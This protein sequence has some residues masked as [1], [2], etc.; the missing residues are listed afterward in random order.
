MPT[1]DSAGTP[2]RLSGARPF[3]LASAATLAVVSLG[4]PWSSLPV[5]DGT[6]PWTATMLGT[7]H[8]V[9]VFA[10]LAALGVWWGLTRGSR[11][12]AWT[13]VACAT[14]ALPL[15]P[16]GA[17]SAPGRLVFAVAIVLT[18]LALASGASRRM[19]A[20]EAR[21]DRG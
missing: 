1:A 6:N 13:G 3:L 12:W 11:V 14:L 15:Q 2:D 17:A 9:R 16:Y 10:P 21:R 20:A 18:V 5:D 19:S 4:L 7:H 8:A